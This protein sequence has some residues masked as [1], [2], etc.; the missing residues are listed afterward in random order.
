MSGH[1]RGILQGSAGEKRKAKR[2][3]PFWLLQAT[4][5]Q[6]LQLGAWGCL[7]LCPLWGVNTCLVRAEPS[8]GAE[9]LL[10]LKPAAQG[11][12][13]PLVHL[14]PAQTS[15]YAAWCSPPRM[16]YPGG[17]PV[18]ERCEN[19]GLMFFHLSAYLYYFILFG[20]GLLLMLFTFT[21]L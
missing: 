17:L 20:Y 11:I 7:V 1:A 19:L 21:K 2:Q 9:G 4:G 18:S 10:A 13:W 12:S 5:L 8:T 6:R 15:A 3:V 14:N 16:L